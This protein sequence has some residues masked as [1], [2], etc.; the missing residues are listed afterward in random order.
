MASIGVLVIILACAAIQYFKGSLTTAV[1]ML[2][3]AISSAFAA[4]GYYELLAGYLGRYMGGMAAWA[5]VICF[6]LVFIVVFAVLQTAIAQFL[7]QPIDLGQWPERIGRPVC[8][9]LLGWAVAGV[10]LT[11][12]SLAPLPL[13]YP[14]QRFED[15]RPDPDRPHRVLLNADGFVSGGFALISRGSFRAMQGAQSF[16]A[17]RAGF[18]DQLY[19]NRL[20]IASKVSR[21]TEDPAIEVPRRAA[22]WEAPEGITDGDGGALPARPGKVLML[23]RIGFKRA[24]LRDSS[25]FTLSQVRL[26]CK[27]RDQAKRPLAGKGRP[28]YPAG[29]M[30]EARQ[31]ALKGLDEQVAL[32][33]RDF[34]RDDASVRW[35]DFGF[36]VPSGLVPVLAQFKWNNMVE[37]PP[38]VTGDQAPQVIPL[39]RRQAPRPAEETPPTPPDGNTPASTNTTP[40]Q[41]GGLSPLSQGVVGNPGGEGP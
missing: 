36:Y 9:V 19:L 22:V 6:V 10:T 8:G 33:S 5:E 1:A 37:V 41:E 32:E 20:G 23:A 16:G 7:R 27:P 25:P 18:L 11:A 34:G 17:V 14:Y 15:R 26:I 2:I 12:A 28:V 3:A 13:G 29:Y 40:P 39:I 30:Q 31:L 4:M 35:I 38:P 21:R 24:A